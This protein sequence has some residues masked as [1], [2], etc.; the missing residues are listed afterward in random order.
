MDKIKDKRLCYLHIGLEKTGTTTIQKFLFENFKLLQEHGV[1]FPQSLCHNTLPILCY[2]DEKVDNF[3]LGI[4]KKNIEHYRKRELQRLE[5]ELE[6]SQQQKVIFS[7][8]LIQS[9]LTKIEE[10]KRLKAIL[11]QLGFEDFKIILYLREQIGL[12]RSLFYEA[13]K[14]DEITLKEI[15]NFL[16][17]QKQGGKF[18]FIKKDKEDFQHICN[19]K[20]TIQ[21]YSQIFGKENIIVQIYEKESWKNANLID[22]FLYHLGIQKDKKFIVPKDQN[23][24]INGLG[25]KILDCFNQKFPAFLDEEVNYKRDQSFLKKV[26][27]AFSVDQDKNNVLPIPQEVLQHFWDTNIENNEWV[28][29]EFFPH[30]S[31]LFEKCTPLLYSPFI[32]SMDNATCSYLDW[33]DFEKSVMFLLENQLNISQ[34][35]R[36]ENPIKRALKWLKSH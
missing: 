24:T 6:N 23:K 13:I 31:E 34:N 30:R 15:P 9:R 14:W 29:R 18:Y 25:L 20:Q 7:S 32:P 27:L 28:R 36:K 22:D 11:E 1:L 10:I 12:V 35:S 21:W 19:H 33:K 26:Q 2:L 5:K 8:E 17:K 16:E 3:V 4:G